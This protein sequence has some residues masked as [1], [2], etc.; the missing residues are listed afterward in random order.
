MLTSLLKI[1]S[2]DVDVGAD[3]DAGDDND[4]RTLDH[5]LLRGPLD[6]LELADDSRMKLP[7]QLPSERAAGLAGRR[8]AS[9]GRGARLPSPP[10]RA[11]RRALARLA[12]GAPLRSR[13]ACHRARS[14]SGSGEAGT[15]AS[16][17]SVKPTTG[18]PMRRMRAAPAAV[19]LEL[20]AVGRVP[21]G[22]LRLVVAPLALGAGER[23]FTLTPALPCSSFLFAGCF[24]EIAAGGLEPPT[25][26]L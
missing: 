20:D 24:E 2:H 16:V 4:D 6:L 26:G 25:R 21:L 17:T 15:C 11:G 13:L 18:L 10:P 9:A 1:W 19:L 5:V 22:L 7:A 23:D 3:D 14:R 8:A 12:A